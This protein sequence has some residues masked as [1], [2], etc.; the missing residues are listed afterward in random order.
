MYGTR[1]TKTKDREQYI[2]R[3][4]E[5]LFSLPMDKANSDKTKETDKVKWLKY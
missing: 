3:K 5:R 4:V 1:R 2:S